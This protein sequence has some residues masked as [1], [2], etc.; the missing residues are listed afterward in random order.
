MRRFTIVL[1][2]IS[3]LTSLGIVTTAQEASAA[4]HPRARIV[5]RVFGGIAAGLKY[6]KPM[7]QCK[8]HNGD[9]L[10]LQKQYGR[11]SWHSVVACRS[12]LQ[13]LNGTETFQYGCARPYD[14]DYYRGWYRALLVWHGRGITSPRYYCPDDRK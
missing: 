7:R 14:E 11:D 4:C 1:C 5:E 8:P 10:C 3:L 6:S 2:L 12:D 9:K 13:L